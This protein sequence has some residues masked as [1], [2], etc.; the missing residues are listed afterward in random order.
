MSMRSPGF[1]FILAALVFGPLASA[2]AAQTGG[3][4]YL[5]FISTTRAPSA[6]TCASAPDAWVFCSGFEEGNKAVWDDYD[7]NPDSENQIIAN[8]G[9]LAAAN[10]HAMRLRVPAGRGGSDLVKVLP[11]TY[12]RLYTRWYI[13][14]EPG[15][16][17]GAPNHGG[18]LHA[19]DRDYLGRSGIRPNGD[20]YFGAWVDYRTQSP[21]TP[22]FYTY[23]RGMYQDCVDPNGSCWGDSLPCLY[24]D[25]GTFCTNPAHRP[26]QP[27]VNLQS[28]VW[29]CVETYVDAG[30]PSSNG[31]GATGAMALWVNGQSLGSWD[32]L[33]LRTTPSVRLSLLWLSLFH[34]DDAHSVAGVLYDDVVVSTERV[35]CPTP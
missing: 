15:F 25:G 14:Y 31:G 20:D 33:W 7:G 29:Y 23:Y 16:N 28:G 26:T 24:D 19:G 11:A 21:H 12:D 13:L 1:T 18:G 30:T 22:F 34:H 9:P 17:F 3:S 6:A 2:A 10:N 8:S 5:R 4:I 35:G 32:H 27:L